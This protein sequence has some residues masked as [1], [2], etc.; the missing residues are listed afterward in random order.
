LH[1]GPHLRLADIRTV[2]PMTEEDFIEKSVRLQLGGVVGI[3]QSETAMIRALR[4][5]SGMA[6]AC[7]SGGQEFLMLG[8]DG[9]LRQVTKKQIAHNP[10]TDNALSSVLAHGPKFGFVVDMQDRRLRD[11]TDAGQTSF[12][13]FCFNRAK[14]DSHRILWPLPHY[15]DVTGDQ[16]VAGVSPDQV[17]WQDKVP[18]AVWRG[19][20]GGRAS[21]SGPGRGEGMRLKTALRKFQAGQ[22]QTETLEALFATN[23]RYRAVAFAEGDA[24]YDFG[25]VDGDGYIISQTPLLAKFEKPRMTRAQMQAYRYIAVLR[26][27]DVGSGFYWVMNSGSVG[28]VQDTPF[29]T[30]ASGHFEPWTH[31]IPFSEDCSDLDARLAWGEAHLAACEA[32]TRASAIQCRLLAQPHTRRKILLKVVQKL[33]CLLIDE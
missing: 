4:G 16:F 12:P 26:G 15:H 7:V 14:S 19:I 30:F 24:K 9:A 1:C 25:F 33:N 5:S 22:M 18:R 32:M 31:Y 20:A 28:L 8:P 10:K 17:A 29:E 11:I 21:G 23:P 6:V 13:V 2:K 3:A 27:L